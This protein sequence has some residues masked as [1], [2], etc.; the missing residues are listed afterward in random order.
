MMSIPVALIDYTHLSAVHLLLRDMLG[1]PKVTVQIPH[2]RNP[3]VTS[4]IDR[5][6]DREGGGH[7][8]ICTRITLP[9][10]PGG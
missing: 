4:K 2:L 9:I 7:K 8:T 10:H 3:P 6:T 1:D 5:E